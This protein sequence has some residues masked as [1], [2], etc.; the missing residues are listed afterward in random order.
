MGRYS[1]ND[2]KLI[3]SRLLILDLHNHKDWLIRDIP[4]AAHALFDPDDIEIVYF[5][6][7]N[8][9]FKH[10]PFFELLRKGT[11]TLKFFGP[12]SVH[13]YQITSE[14]PKEAGVFSHPDL[15]RMTNFHIIQSEE[16]KII[17]AMGAPNFIFIADPATMKFIRRIE[18]KN[19]DTPCYIGTFSPSP[20]GIK[21]Y[22]QTTRSFQIVNISDGSPEMIRSLEFDHTCS[23]HMEL[24]NDTDW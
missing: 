20:D 3:P 17:A 19:Q 24:S 21:L 22:I 15:F 11:Y 14:G 8:F 4:N 2:G 16:G 6:N 23:N 13:K 18:I 7:H 5:S 1:G 9:Q 12:A 10:T